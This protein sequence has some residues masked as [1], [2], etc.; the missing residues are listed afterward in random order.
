MDA[1]IA[2]MV[3][4]VKK[5][6]QEA[7]EGIVDL[8]KDKIYR[9]CFR[10]VG[11][12]HEAEDLAQETFLRAYRNISKYNSEYKFSTWIFRI[13]TNLCIDR[14]RK[15]KPD[16]YLDAEVPGTDGATMYSQLSSEEPL[17][18]EVVTENEEWNELQS[19]IMKLPEKYRTAILL[20]YVEDLSLEEISKIM[21]IPVPTVKTRI[22][23]GRE[24]L[25]KVF[26]MVV[27]TR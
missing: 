25:K 5:G 16:Y 20:K 15:K 26:Q 21:D 2:N 17:P 8:F 7:F 13:A 14:L 10:M 3:T 11:N 18:E 12:G 9:H 22:H 24:A 6:D 19:E 23:R 27:K 4:Q 1:L